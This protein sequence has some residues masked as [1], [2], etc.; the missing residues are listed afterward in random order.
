[1]NIPFTDRELRKIICMSQALDVPPERVVI[2]AVRMYDLITTHGFNRTMEILQSPEGGCMGD[3]VEN[4]EG[5][6]YDAEPEGE[7]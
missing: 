3:D 4:V 7:E 6:R 2:Q 5:S 1:M